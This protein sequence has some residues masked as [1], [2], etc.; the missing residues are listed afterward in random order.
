MTIHIPAWILWTVGIGF[1]AVITILAVLGAIF[2][3]WVRDL[4]VW[5]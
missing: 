4:E 1:G 2:C 5:R 3:A